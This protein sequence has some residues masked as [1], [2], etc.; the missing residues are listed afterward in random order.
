MNRVKAWRRM[1]ECNRWAVKLLWI[2]QIG[3]LSHDF[4]NA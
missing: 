1:G 3:M 4:Y 2:R